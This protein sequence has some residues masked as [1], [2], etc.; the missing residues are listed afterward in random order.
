MIVLQ[1]ENEKKKNSWGI[2]KDIY[3]LF[4]NEDTI[5]GEV[6]SSTDIGPC[7][8]QTYM[9][10][11]IHLVRTQNISKIYHFLPPDRH[12]YVCVSGGKIY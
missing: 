7:P 11:I 3:Q 8:C 9:I 5:C 4:S 10:G 6:A 12:T 2:S 1:P